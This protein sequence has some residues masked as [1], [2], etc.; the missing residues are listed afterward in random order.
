MALG[1]QHY[2]AHPPV[3]MTDDQVSALKVTLAERAAD[4][5]SLLGRHPVQARQALR[6]VLDG[7]LTFTP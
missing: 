1:A 7:Q 3:P 2:R 6:K 5:A 4:V